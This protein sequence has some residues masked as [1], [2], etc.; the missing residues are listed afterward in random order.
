MKRRDF[1]TLLSACAVWPTMARAQQTGK[2]ARVGYLG[3]TLASRDLATRNLVDRLRELGWEEGRNLDV[4]ERAYGSDLEL[5]AS[6]AAEFLRNKEI[7]R[8]H[9]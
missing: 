8:A 7:G 9:V 4:D 6:A 5:V 3:P 2:V 1:L